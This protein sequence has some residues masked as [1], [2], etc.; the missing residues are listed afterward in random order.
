M[1]N[2]WM[3]WSAKGVENP[4]NLLMKKYERVFYEMFL[5]SNG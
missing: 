4:G 3:S 5:V 1:K 2:K